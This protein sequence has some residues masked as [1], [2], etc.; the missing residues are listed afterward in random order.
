VDSTTTVTHRNIPIGTPCEETTIYILNEEDE[1]MGIYQ[2]G[3]IVYKSEYL[4]LGYLNDEVQTNKV[5]TIDP[6]AKKGRVYRS[7]DAGMFLPTGEIVFTGRKDGQVKLNGVRIELSEIEQHLLKIDGIE[8][9][10]V[11]KKVLRGAEKLVAYLRSNETVRTEEISH[12]L[13]QSL[14]TYMIPAHYVFLEK[15]PLTPT[16]KISRMDFPE[17]QLIGEAMNFPENE[18]EEKLAQIWSE[19]L[20]IELADVRT[21][22]GLFTMGGNSIQIIRLKNKI[23]KDEFFGVELSLEDFFPDPTIKSLSHVIQLAAKFKDIEGM[24][25]QNE[26]KNESII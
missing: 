5:F 1:E 7:G 13:S 23:Q 6:I 22:Q 25:T 2:E 9:A 24:E 15:F 3:E 18:T 11:L 8:E 14:P 17:P 12:L 19:I 4:A 10:I 26:F 16:G 20:R 21:D